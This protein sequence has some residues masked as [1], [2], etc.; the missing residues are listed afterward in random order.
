MK[1]ID[2]EKVTQILLAGLLLRTEPRPD[3]RMLER[4]IKVE[5]GTISKLFPQR[6][7]S[8]GKKHPTKAKSQSKTAKPLAESSP[9]V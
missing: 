3:V 1:D 2:H 4:L 5:D 6:P 7:G 8:I 9:D